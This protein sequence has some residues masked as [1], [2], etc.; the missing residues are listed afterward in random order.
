MFDA[1]V[2]ER[3]FGVWEDST[4]DDFVNAVEKSNYERRDFKAQNG[5]TWKD[6]MRRAQTFIANVTS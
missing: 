4:Y 5:E 3:N 2:R 1:R 6:V